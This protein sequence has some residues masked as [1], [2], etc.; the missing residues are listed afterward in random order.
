MANKIL[1]GWTGGFP[2]AA[3]IAAIALCA[4]SSGLVTWAMASNIFFSQIVRIQ[5]DRGHAPATNG[6][7]RY[8]RHP[9]YVGAI[10]F[11]L[12]ISSLLA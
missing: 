11:E 7:Y 1:Y 2:L 12:G 4:A 3:Q 6:P 8:V 9:G 10:L 5:A